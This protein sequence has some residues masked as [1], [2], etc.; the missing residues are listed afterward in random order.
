M[1]IKEPRRLAAPWSPQCLPTHP[2]PLG[3][4]IPPSPSLSLPLPCHLLPTPSTG[5]GPLVGCADWLSLLPQDSLSAFCLKVSTEYPPQAQHY[6]TKITTGPGLLSS[7]HARAG[8]RQPPQQTSKQ[9]RLGEQSRDT[10]RI[11]NK[12][13]T[14]TEKGSLRKDI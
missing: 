6:V 12:D 9:G 8:R 4:S 7:F 13:L 3:Q 11:S 14:L 10:P 5:W 2:C 1:Q